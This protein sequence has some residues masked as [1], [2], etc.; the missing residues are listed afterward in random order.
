VC[1]YDNV[2]LLQKFFFFPLAGFFFLEYIVLF[3]LAAACGLHHHSY[4][5]GFRVSIDSAAVATS[6]PRLLE[7]R[8]GHTVHCHK[9]WP[10]P[11][12]VGTAAGEAAPRR[13]KAARY[14]P[15]SHAPATQREPP[16]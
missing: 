14:A 7:R 3:L 8:H 6:R 9:L 1:V 4:C 2:S 5:C 10:A 11:R 15:P 13:N 12:P 16:R